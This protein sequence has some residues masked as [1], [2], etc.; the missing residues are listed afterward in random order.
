M[1][2]ETIIEESNSGS[3]KDKPQSLKDK[4]N[5]RK[6]IIISGGLGAAM[7]AAA[8]LASSQMAFAIQ[9]E[10]G[11]IEMARVE[12]TVI[13]TGE[14]Q[15]VEPADLSLNVDDSMSFNE[16]F[17]AAREEVGAGGVFVWRDNIYNTF[18]KEEWEGMDAGD[19]QDYWASVEAT[20]EEVNEFVH[21]SDGIAIETVEDEF[22]SSAEE[23]EGRDD[24]EFYP[25]DGDQLDESTD[26]ESTEDNSV[27]FN[28]DDDFDSDFDSDAPVGEWV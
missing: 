26:D 16:A 8:G 10:E 24:S 2:N 6:D 15:D 22:E 12:D 7:G 28:D 11:E 9:N 4:L 13:I 5:A 21:A 23:I 14:D 1:N 27:S 19:K 17:G 25:G 3:E 18:Y 20:K